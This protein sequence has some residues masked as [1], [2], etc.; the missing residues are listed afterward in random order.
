MRIVDGHGLTDG[1]LEQVYDL[2]SND[3]LVA[4]PTETV[5][6]L[7][8]NAWSETAIAKIFKA[9][10]RPANNPLIVHVASVDHLSQAVAMPLS[11]VVQQRLDA[12]VDLWPGPLTVV[13]PRG[14]RIADCVTAGRD[15]VAVRIPSHRV[16]LS[17]LERCPFPI[18][19]PSANPSK[20]V[21][22]T[23][24]QH[25]VDG[26]SGVVDLVVDGGPCSV[27]VEST[28][29][30]LHGREPKLL[31]PGLITGEEIARRLGV[32]IETLHPPADS[33]Q[34]L[35]APGMMKEHYSPNTPLMRI[36]E[37]SDQIPL[38]RQGR[39]AFQP[40]SEAVAQQYAVVEVLS[41]DGDLQEIAQH[42]FAAFRRLDQQGLDCI[43]IDECANE[44]IGL[45]IM[46]RIVR[47]AAKHNAE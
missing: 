39:I 17:I 24:A 30:S 5:Y 47:A 45:A 20:Y 10:R 21:S 33:H 15:T 38:K 4:I 29:V 41:A 36:S 26:L 46:D 3:S 34:E 31:R 19:A 22:P 35:L 43:V 42:L 7:A 28:I 27:G 14:Q 12:L 6:G 11:S 13:L 1:M 8:A 32:S 44:G 23:T 40:I 37:V 25:C 18:A 2:L 9:K 16:A